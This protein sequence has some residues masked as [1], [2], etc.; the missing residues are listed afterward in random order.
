[1]LQGTRVI[2]IG[3]Y[4]AA[5]FAARI[6][7]DLG[8]DVVKLENVSGGDPYRFVKHDYD[9][10]LPPDFTHRYFQYNRGKQSIALDLKDKR[11]QDIFE[12]LVRDA[13]VL[14]ENLRPGAMDN[15]GLGY[16]TVSEWNED[17]IF[18][19]ISGYGETGQYNDRGAVDPLIQS[20]SGLVDQNRAT[21]DRPVLTGLYLADIIGALFA[22]NSIVAAMA[23]DELGGHIDLSLLDGLVSLFN[24]EAAVYSATGTSPPENRATFEPQGVFETEDGALT[25]YVMDKHWQP[26]CEI[27]GFDDWVEADRYDSVESR[28][29][30][31]ERIMDRVQNKLREE[32]T[33]Y[34]LDAFLEEEF[35][36]APVN[37]V[38]DIFEDESISQRG[39]VEWS[40][41]DVVGDHLRLNI[42]AVVEQTK[43]SSK[44]APRFG[45]HTTEILEQLGY[46]TAEISQLFSDDVISD[47]DHYYS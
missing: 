40:H 12:K 26:L 34:W 8:C 16:A 25:V 9:S 44:S 14:L 37:T 33:E 13:D 32:T 10:E 18:C 30:F 11:G 46:S 45:E 43:T 15:F 2:S 39:T 23:S 35:L 22:V 5:P 21:E 17:I 41:D 6:L 4:L 42:P 1:M 28:R 36:V 7:S 29:E 3:N 19:S 47:F 31:R 20:M 27:L 24:H 38:D